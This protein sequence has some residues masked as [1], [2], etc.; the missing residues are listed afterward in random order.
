MHFFYNSNEKKIIHD[1]L[2]TSKLGGPFRTSNLSL[3]HAMGV[4]ASSVTIFALFLTVQLPYQS[5]TFK[6]YGKQE[7][8]NIL[9]NKYIKSAYLVIKLV[10]QLIQNVLYKLIAHGLHLWPG[11]VVV[12]A[13]DPVDNNKEAGG[14]GQEVVREH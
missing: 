12:D 2:Q 10:K 7:F 4:G 11:R 1:W 5:H 8:A 6:V 14:E 3:S 9:F 13:Q